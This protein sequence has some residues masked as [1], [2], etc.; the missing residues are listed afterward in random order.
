MKKLVPLFLA[1]TS[2]TALAGTAMTGVT[3]IPGGKGNISKTMLVNQAGDTVHTWANIG[4]PY[5]AFLT[6][7][8]TVISSTGYG[9]GPG[10]PYKTMT[11]TNWAGTVIRSWTWTSP[12]SGTLHHAN[13]YMPNGHWL[14]IGY[15]LLTNAGLK[16][17][18]SKNLGIAS[19]KVTYTGAVYNEHILEYD[20]VAGKVVWD[21]SAAKH[22]SASP[23]PRRI[24]VNKFTSSGGGPGGMGGSSGDVLHFN[25]VVYDPIRDLI[26]V[27]V[28]MMNEIFVIDH[29]TATPSDTTSGKYKHG[30]DILFRWG[31]PTNYGGKGGTLCDVVHGG[32]FVPSN[33][34]NAGNPMF[35]CNTDNGVLF[36]TAKGHS[37][38]Y[39]I[40]PALAD[41]GF[42]L[43][44]SGFKAS[45]VFDWFSTSGN[46]ESSGNFGFPQRLANGNTVI[47]FS[48]AGRV[49]EISDGANVLEYTGCSYMMFR[50]T[51]YPTTY[52]GI[53]NLT[54]IYTGPSTGVA[55]VESP[56]GTWLRTSFADRTLRLG[57]I[58]SDAPIRIVDLS[59]R[60]RW[61]GKGDG[62][63]IALSIAGWPN[64][65][66]FLKV[67]SGPSTITKGLGLFF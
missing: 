53:R 31:A 1:A 27:S 26:L 15:E 33:Y 23:H 43:G 56:R 42:V 13:N 16:D 48:K 30:G 8:G 41:S 4:S 2:G 55:P 49:V 66:Y 21:W 65:T 28:H 6:D 63:E 46:Y 10:A 32:N 60:I 12:T 47:S 50:A 64:G 29:S 38:A 37:V 44:D 7:S 54:S 14:A 35:F 36:P 9:T 61:E 62:S 58:E 51:R 39:E 59:G 18:M 40:H 45:V 11:E 22:F 52:P 20:P 17:S 57:G 34:P 3:L 5:S 67:G 24:N 19:S 25:S